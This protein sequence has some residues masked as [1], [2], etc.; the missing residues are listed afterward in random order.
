MDNCAYFFTGVLAGVAGITL[1]A[2]LDGNYR[3]LTDKK[4]KR[5]PMSN[6]ANENKPNEMSD[7]NNNEA[8]AVN[9]KPEAEPQHT[10]NKNK[11][12]PPVVAM[13]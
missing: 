7:E 5:I 12:V 11:T 9:E 2:L 1:L 8:Q 6:R 4:E 13:A 10:Q 3:F